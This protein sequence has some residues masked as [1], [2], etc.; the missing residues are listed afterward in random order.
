MQANRAFFKPYAS[1]HISDDDGCKSSPSVLSIQLHIHVSVHNI[2]QITTE[3]MLPILVPAI[4]METH[5]HTHQKCKQIH[6]RFRL[7]FTTKRGKSRPCVAWPSRMC[8]CLPVN[9]PCT[10]MQRQWNH[11]GPHLPERKQCHSQ[12]KGWFAREACVGAAILCVRQGHAC[13]SICRS[14]SHPCCLEGLTIIQ[15]SLSWF[16]CM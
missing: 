2:Y 7:K 15:V 6:Q 1:A 16:F 10:S 8:T 3:S 9:T 14:T 4:H 5:T 11:I 13:H 12:R